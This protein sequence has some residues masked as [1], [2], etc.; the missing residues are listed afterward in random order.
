MEQSTESSQPDPLSSL[1]PRRPS[2]PLDQPD[3]PQLWVKAAVRRAAGRSTASLRMLPDWLIV[4]AQKAGTSSLFDLLGQHPSVATPYLKELDYF[5]WFHDRSLGWYRAFFPLR[6]AGL[7]TGEASP[8]YF[9]DERSAARIAGVLPVARIIVLLRDPT[10]RTVSHY[11]HVHKR[12]LEPLGLSEALDAEPERLAG[13][14]QRVRDD[15]GY[16]SMRLRHW[17]YVDRGRYAEQL[18]RWLAVYPP[19]QVLVVCA[20]TLFRRPDQAYARTLEFL[21]LSPF[22]PASFRA[23]NVNSYDTPDAAIRRRLDAE[24][25]ADNERLFALIGERF[26]WGSARPGVA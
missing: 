26:A 1:R 7:V 14:K 12:G 22:V 4:G 18:E 6:R 19:D 9:Y 20:E 8:Y 23:Q 21:G 3:A 25:A 11:H 5:S 17:S 10:D 24:F 15:P 16:V 2:F 13:E